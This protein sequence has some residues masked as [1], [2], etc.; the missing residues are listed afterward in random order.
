MKSSIPYEHCGI[1]GRARTMSRRI[2]SSR[3]A[4]LA[5]IMYLISPDMFHE[6]E[7]LK[8]ECIVNITSPCKGHVR[9]YSTTLTTS[10]GVA[11]IVLA[12]PLS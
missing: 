3:L 7:E 8:M 2:T 9:K 6:P 11:S 12:V 10:D 4:G 5:L 1:G